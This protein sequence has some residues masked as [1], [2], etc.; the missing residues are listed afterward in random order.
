MVQPIRKLVVDDFLEEY[1]LQSRLEYEEMLSL[2]PSHKRKE[3]RTAV[4]SLLLE[5]ITFKDALILAFIKYEK[6]QYKE[7]AV[8]RLIFPRSTRFCA[9]LATYLKPLEKKLI[10]TFNL[11]LIHI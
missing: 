2:V 11:S 1:G 9:E 7:G 3:Y 8:P 10:R 5:G 6:K 4:Q